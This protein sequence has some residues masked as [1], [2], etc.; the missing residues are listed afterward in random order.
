MDFKLS[1]REGAA[2]W[3]RSCIERGKQEFFATSIE[4]T[5]DVAQELLL[6]NPFNRGITEARVLVYAD[7]ID[8]DR[9]E[10]NGQPI[11][12]SDDGFLT[13]GQHRCEAVVLAGK[14]I[15]TSIAFGVSYESRKTT[16]QCKPKGAADFLAMD[17][18]PYAKA[19]TGVARMLVIM[20]RTGNVHQPNGISHSN[21]FDF[22]TRNKDSLLESTAFTHQ[23]LAKLKNVISPIVLAFCHYLFKQINSEAADTFCSQII[24]GEALAADDPAM[25][26]R[27]KL[28]STS[29]ATR[30]AKT[31]IVFHGWN[32]FRRGER[33]TLIRISG[34]LPELL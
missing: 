4:L 30:A 34:K 1:P 15:K 6:R 28:I 21:V 23:H 26:V 22:A 12:V 25:A 18:A 8:N 3:L 11:I 29:R 31:E 9:W 10:F 27:N 33:R 2:M 14:S 5:P 17:G 19:I 16:D 32:A 24:H 7:D 20:E 13:D